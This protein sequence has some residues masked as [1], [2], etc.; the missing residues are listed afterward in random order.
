MCG[1]IVKEK[2]FCLNKMLIIIHVFTGLSTACGDTP[3]KK[4][5]L[6]VSSFITLPLLCGNFIPLAMQLVFSKDDYYGYYNS[7]SPECL[8]NGYNGNKNILEN[9]LD[10]YVKCKESAYSSHCES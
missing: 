1:K 9:C 8:T 5:L 3:C 2:T 6:L 10:D 7:Y 4:I